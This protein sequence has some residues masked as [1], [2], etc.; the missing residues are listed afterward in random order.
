MQVTID[1]PEAIL[2]DY[3]EMKG[4]AEMR[5][6][7]A[8]INSSGDGI[9]TIR[10]ICVM[11]G[12]WYGINHYKEITGSLVDEGTDDEPVDVRQGRREVER[13]RAIIA[14]DAL[15]ITFQTMGQYRSALLKPIAAGR[16]KEDS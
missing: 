8:A 12:I 5:Q 14:D 1:A 4:A 11:A 13:I 2:A 9:H 7:A 6:V 3:A 10:D 16:G 15:A